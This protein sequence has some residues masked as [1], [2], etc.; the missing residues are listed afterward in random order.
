V[1]IEVGIDERSWLQHSWELLTGGITG[2]TLGIFF[3]VIFG[4]IGWVRGALYGAIGLI[5]L[6]LEGFLGELG[7]GAGQYYSQPRLLCVK[8]STH[9]FD[10]G[11]Q[12]DYCT[13]NFIKGSRVD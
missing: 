5:G 13:S 12:R 7:I 1:N 8:R 4:S 10:S 11:I 6:A 9:H 3:F 2:T